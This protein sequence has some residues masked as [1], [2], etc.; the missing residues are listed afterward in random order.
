MLFEFISTI[1]AGIDSGQYLEILSNGIPIGIVRDTTSG[2]F[3]AYAVGAIASN[4]PLLP[5]TVPIQFLIPGVNMVQDYIAFPQSYQQSSSL[6]TVLKSLQTNIS[7]LQATIALIELGKIPS[8]ALEAVNLRQTLKLKKEV[9]E[10]QLELKNGF[11]DLQKALKAQGAEVRQIVKEVVHDINFEQHCTVLGRAYSLFMQACNRLQSAMESPDISQRKSEIDSAREM[12]LEVLADYI[13][14]QILEKVSAP[15]QL[16]RFE[17]A[18]AIEQ[19]IVITYQVQNQVAFVSDRLCHLRDKI[20]EHICTVINNCETY[21]ELNFLFPE[22]SRVCKHDLPILEVWQ[23]RVDW[24]RSLSPVEIKLLAKNNCNDS[25][26]ADTLVTNQTKIVLSVPPEQL[27]YEDLAEK[28]HFY[29]L[30]DQMIFMFKPVL[31]QEYEVYI[32]QQAQAAGHKILIPKNLQQVSDMTVANLYYYFKVRDE[33]N[34]EETLE[35]ITA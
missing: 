33:S 21:D 26:L 13:N 31:R 16:R 15:G 12:F 25:E 30:L 35:A 9:E 28:S 20:K 11:I 32:N 24:L 1:K 10:M 17:C 18:W 5:L 7:V 34:I 19:A 27:V 22:I 8:V 29:S 23:A 2:S 3:L 14:P 6:Q 4:H